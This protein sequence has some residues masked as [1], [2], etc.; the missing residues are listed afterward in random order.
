MPTEVMDFIVDLRGE[1]GD[2]GRIVWADDSTG[3]P[4]GMQLD[5]TIA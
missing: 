5:I 4:R 1:H 3:I 2:I